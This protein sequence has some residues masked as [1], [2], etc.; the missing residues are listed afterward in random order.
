M[1]QPT[2][3]LNLAHR[4]ARKAAPENTLAAFS[5]AQQLGAD[6]VE[7][8]V[9]RCA[10]GEMVVT[11]DDDLSI[12]S[13]GRGRVSLASLAA[14]KELDFGSHFA[15]QFAGEKIPTLPEV[16][17]VLGEQMF[18]NIEIKT[19]ALRPLAEAVSV[20]AIIADY[21]L[22]Q[23]VVVSSFNPLVLHHIRKLDRRIPTGLLYQFRLPFNTRR[24]ISAPFLGLAALHPE[25]RLVKPRFIERARR[26]GYRINTWT[27]N[28]P[29]EMRRLIT[30][31]VD[32]II[33]DYP[34]RL[35]AVLRECASA[36]HSFFLP[37]RRK[38]INT[39]RQ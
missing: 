18:I 27:V 16:I 8:D 36:A 30:L 21:N 22:Y 15:P 39:G 32:A 7:L 29:E 31:G 6:G 38:T 4:G 9:I 3:P 28:E 26:L 12:W 35:K 17:N 25:A 10:T 23:R 37:K 5:V 24:P 13:N 33:T 1:M 19:I 2:L 11:H 34:D 20:A 14:L